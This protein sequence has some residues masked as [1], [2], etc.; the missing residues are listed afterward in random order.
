MKIQILTSISMNLSWTLSSKRSDFWSFFTHK[1][2]P[3]FK[4]FPLLAVRNLIHLNFY[5]KKK[6]YNR[7]YQSFLSKSVSTQNLPFDCM[8]SNMWLHDLCINYN[9]KC[10][11]IS[12]NEQDFLFLIFVQFL[13]TLTLFTLLGFQYQN[14]LFFTI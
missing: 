8:S 4:F 12:V 10:T 9:S 5:F 3:L 7:L 11:I 13:L 14:Y 2:I 1:K 6:I